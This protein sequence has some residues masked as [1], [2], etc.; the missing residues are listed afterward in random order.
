MLKHFTRPDSRTERGVAFND[1]FIFD[2]FLP[3]SIKAF[4]VSAH[5]LTIVAAD[6][7]K[8]STNV[9]CGPTFL[10]NLHKMLSFLLIEKPLC[11]QQ[12]TMFTKF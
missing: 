6:I 10:P 5:Y 4:S 3:H 2:E 8:H 9:F 1:F 7:S 11:F 12:S